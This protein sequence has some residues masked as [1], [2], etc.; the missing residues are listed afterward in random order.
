MPQQSRLSIFIAELKRRRVF[1][2]AAVYGG[3]AFV[4]VQII[5]GTFEVMGIPAWI[6]RLAI[7]LLALGLPLAVG[8]AWVFD[9]TPEGIVR[10]DRASIAGGDVT[11]SQS[12][13]GTSGKPLTSNRALIV[14]AVLAV[15]FGVWS[16]WGGSEETG[17]RSIAV[18]P[19]ANLMGD[20]EQ[21]YFVDGMHEALIGTL[22]RIEALKVIS[23][24]STLGYRN[25][26]KRM[27][28]IARE[29]GVDA[30]I[31]GSVLRAGDRVRITAQLIHG[32]SDEH[33]W[34]ANY[35]RPLDDILA[36]QNEVATAIAEEIE[37]TMTPGER[38]RLAESRKISPKAHEHYL[39]GLH[40]W[41]KR[42]EEGFYQALEHFQ[43]SVDADPGYAPAYAGL[44]LTHEL[45]GEYQFM[46]ASA[47][48]P[49]AIANAEEA[50]RLDPNL[51]E[52]HTALAAARLYYYYD[53]ER[54]E[55]GYHKA[56]ALNP[57]YATAYQWLGEL[58]NFL[59]RHEDALTNID[60]ALSI[61]PL[62]KVMAMV[63]GQTLI[64]LG[65]YDEAIAQF[66]ER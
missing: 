44:A 17:I 18:L 8:L 41:N 50:L 53:W 47:S 15:A 46:T 63:R 16:R 30:I 56:I 64:Y 22:S 45:F 49:Q 40:H 55:T 65:R 3:V 4:L 13:G 35:E 26:R 28:E 34:S 36:L 1:R 19:L 62:S 21:D 23:R 2:V 7:V 24:T 14:I 58:N 51:A 57:G 5:D 11:L 27:P 60:K 37:V 33:L 9:I 66:D 38:A 20:A 25:T 54:A 31:E 39:K 10:T 52:A 43:A 32:R 59:G 61:D 29:L 12:K 42:T 48:Y 6:S